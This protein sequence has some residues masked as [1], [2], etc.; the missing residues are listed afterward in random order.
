MAVSDTRR[1]LSTWSLENAT[2]SGYRQNC[3]NEIRKPIPNSISSG[4]LGSI[5]NG[6]AASARPIA[7]LRI[8][9]ARS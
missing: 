6:A 9:T 7:T 1:S 5:A 8:S 2:A 4:T 3:S